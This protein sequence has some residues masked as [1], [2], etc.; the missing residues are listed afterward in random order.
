MKQ[1]KIY[2]GTR[3]RWG[4]KGY[5]RGNA[6]HRGAIGAVEVPSGMVVTIYAS[7]NQGGKRT[8]PFQ[9][10]KYEYARFSYG[11]LN[12]SSPKLIQVSETAFEEREMLRL[13][14][15]Q[16][17]GEKQRKQIQKLQPGE[18]WDSRGHKDFPNDRV[19]NIAVPKNAT[20]TIYEDSDKSTRRGYVTLGPGYHKTGDYNLYMKVSSINYALD[21]WKEVST[22]LGGQNNKKPQGLPVAHKVR[23]TGAEGDGFSQYISFGSARVKETNWHVNQSVT[24]SVEIGGETQGWKIGLSTTNESGGGGSTGDTITRDVGITVNGVIGKSGEITGDVLAQLFN[25]DQQVFRV[26][27]NVRTGEMAEQE[28]IRPVEFFEAG[29]SMDHGEVKDYEIDGQEGIDGQERNNG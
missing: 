15:W 8:R 19:E 29:F 6:V 24:A 7:P 5:K 2:K 1:V 14:W 10:G 26:L 27:K 11:W 25:A 13:I 28:G 3:A 9:A 22:R 17:D 21:A 12:D 20:A 16:K 4:S 23:G 18:D